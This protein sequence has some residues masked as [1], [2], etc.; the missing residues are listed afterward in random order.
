MVP[1]KCGTHNFE[2]DSHKDWR[3][4]LANEE[5]ELN[6]NGQCN[7]CGQKTKFSYFGKQKDEQLPIICEDCMTLINSFKKQLV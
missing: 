5:H 7:Y 3:K 1:F 6:G 4:H 2:T